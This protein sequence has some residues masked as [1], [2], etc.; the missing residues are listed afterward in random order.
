MSALDIHTESAVE[1]A[2]RNVL[3]STTALMIAHRASTVMM[4]DQVALLADGRIAAV[5]THSELL[6]TVP[7]YRDL[8]STLDHQPD[9]DAELTFIAQPAEIEC[10]R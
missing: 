6:A 9:E 4:A 5:G 3:S 8:L 7:A 10:P 2:L 1:S